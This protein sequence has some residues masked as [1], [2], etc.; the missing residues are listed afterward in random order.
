MKKSFMKLLTCFIFVM[1]AVGEIMI[2]GVGAK[3]CPYCYC[4]VTVHVSDAV[5]FYDAVNN[6][7][8]DTIIELDD[9]IYL[10]EP[11]NTGVLGVIR[12]NGHK[13]MQAYKV[14][15]PGYYT[16]EPVVTY[17]NVWHDGWTETGYYEVF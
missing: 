12:K 8:A 2:R 17:Q 9:D 7:C 13:I 11:V 14:E 3:P 6:S 5:G 10:D 1:V 16:S 4:G 15:H